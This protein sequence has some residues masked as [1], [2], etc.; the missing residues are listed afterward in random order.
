MLLSQSS[1]R[2]RRYGMPTTN[3]PG[4]ALRRVP[5]RGGIAVKSI[6]AKIEISRILIRDYLRPRQR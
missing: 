4:D 3:A 5:P 2:N 1:R 6:Q